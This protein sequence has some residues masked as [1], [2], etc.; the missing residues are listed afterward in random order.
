[1]PTALIW[2]ATGWIGGQFSKLL[3]AAGYIVIGASSR[4]QNTDEVQHELDSYKPDVV[5]NAAGLTGR[6]NI[7]AL[8]TQKALTTQVNVSGTTFLASACASRNI[9]IVTFATGCIYEYDAAHPIG[10]SGFKETDT[11]NFTGSYYSRTKIAAEIAT[12]ELPGHLILRVRMPITCDASSRC[13]VT[14]IARYERIVNVPN[15]VTVLPD[16][17]PV[18]LDLVN[19][20][21]AGVFNF[22]NPGPVAHADILEA[23]KSIVDPTFTYT[24]MD[25]EAHDKVVVARRSNNTLDTSK[26]QAATD[27]TLP[28]AFESIKRLFETNK[29]VLRP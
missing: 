6:P 26:L 29:P 2:G 17:L 9:Y 23:Y 25:M 14:K 27:I 1:M 22:V 24:V 4:L 11:P 10:S 13:F 19:K 7:D 18:A 21:T 20:R 15:S 16:L 5:V 28:Q 3:S 12:A 8:E